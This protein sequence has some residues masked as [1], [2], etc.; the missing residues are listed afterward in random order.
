MDRYVG[1][2]VLDLGS[3]IAV[4]AVLDCGSWIPNLWV[5]LYG[6]GLQVAIADGVIWC[7]VQRW[8]DKDERC[9]I[10]ERELDKIFFFLQYLLQCNSMFRIAL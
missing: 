7:W 1:F 4:L 3:W 8:G 5:V 9:E 10:E 6:A 2:V